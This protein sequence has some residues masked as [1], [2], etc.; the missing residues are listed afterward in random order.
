[1]RI[2][3]LALA[4]LMTTAGLALAQTQTPSPAPSASAP[5]SA[6]APA[7]RLH[8]QPAATQAAAT[9]AAG[10]AD[11]AA[12]KAKCGSDPVVWGNPNSKVYHTADSRYY[13]KTKKG[14]YL[15]MKEATAQGYH[16]AKASPIHAKK[17]AGST[18]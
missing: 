15:C 12:A 1:M 16:A 6:A 14:S 4:V 5:P 2:P 3:A 11:E 10:S 8:R 7:G 9:P 18:S 17:P 13:G